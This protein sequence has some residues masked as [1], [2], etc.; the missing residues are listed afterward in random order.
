MLGKNIQNQCRPIDNTGAI[1]KCIFQITLVTR[2]KLLIEQNDLC[3]K[4]FDQRVDFFQFS[5]ADKRL[6]IG[7]LEALGSLTDHIQPGCI[8]EKG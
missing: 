4:L 2:G 7:M 8:R 1:A 5:G 6:R 3:L